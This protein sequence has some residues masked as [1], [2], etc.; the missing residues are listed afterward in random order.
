MS[1]ARVRQFLGSREARTALR[2]TAVAYGFQ[3]LVHVV[4]AVIVY[5]V[6]ILANNIDP[7]DDVLWIGLVFVF[8]VPVAVYVAVWVFGLCGLA[9]FSTARSDTGSAGPARSR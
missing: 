6:A 7:P 3:V 5:K 2:R 4:I 8:L 1:L 9:L